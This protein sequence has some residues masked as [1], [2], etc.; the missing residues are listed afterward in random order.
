VRGLLFLDEPSVQ[1]HLHIALVARHL[2]EAALTQQVGAGVA[3]GRDVRVRVAHQHRGEG[4]PHALAPRLASGLVHVAVGA[5]DG[6]LEDVV[7][8]AVALGAQRLVQRLHHHGAGYLSGLRAAHAVGDADQ[9][10]LWPNLELDELA[11]AHV[12]VVARE[13]ERDVGVFVVASDP[14][15]VRPSREGDFQSAHG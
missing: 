7:G 6:L 4:G 9:R 3:H 2:T 10:A 15:N 1:E 5:L 14:S 11:V 13:V 8:R 12:H